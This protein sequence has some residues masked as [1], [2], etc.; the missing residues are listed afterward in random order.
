[1]HGDMVRFMAP[2]LIPRL[3]FAGVMCIFLVVHVCR[4]NPDNSAAD[5]SN[6]LIPSNVIEALSATSID[7]KDPYAI[8]SID[9]ESKVRGT[10]YEVNHVVRGVDGEPMLRESRSRN[11]EAGHF[12][13]TSGV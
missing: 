4:M 6:L 3:V 8:S 7:R 12:A 13:N 2:D 11:N 10:I 1:M 5:V 9:A